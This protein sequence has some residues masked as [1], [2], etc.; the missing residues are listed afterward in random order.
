MTPRLSKRGPS[1]SGP[2]PKRRRSP[3][4]DEV[5]KPAR[6]DAK[7]DDDES[8]E[9]PSRKRRSARGPSF[10]SPVPLSSWSVEVS[11]RGAALGWRSV[12]CAEWAV[13]PEREPERIGALVARLPGAKTVGPAERGRSRR[14]NIAA[15]IQASVGVPPHRRRS[16]WSAWSVGTLV[17]ADEDYAARF[18]A[19][20]GDAAQRDLARR[21]ASAVFIFS[22]R[23]VEE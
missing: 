3:L 5:D 8:E 6:D 19:L 10:F 18:E 9:G 4:E 20:R 13:L 12:L 15:L 17:A 1:E 23:R 22:P 16:A 11:V 14:Y 2:P 7:D 21:A